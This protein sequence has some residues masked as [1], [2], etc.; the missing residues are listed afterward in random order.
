MTFQKAF[1][2]LKVVVDDS[3][4]KPLEGFVCS[5]VYNHPWRFGN[6]SNTNYEHFFVPSDENVSPFRIYST[7]KNRLVHQTGGI[8]RPKSGD[9]KISEVRR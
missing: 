9:L 6:R 4:A 8:F 7:G 5:V 1:K 2:G 3:M